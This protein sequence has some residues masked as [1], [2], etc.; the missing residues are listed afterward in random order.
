MGIRFVWGD[1]ARQAEFE[2]VVEGL[3]ANSLGPLVAQNL[4]HRPGSTQ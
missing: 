3:M 2:T 4:L 1:Q